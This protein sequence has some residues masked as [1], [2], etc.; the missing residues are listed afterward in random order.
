MVLSGVTSNHNPN[1][2]L[3]CDLCGPISVI[4]TTVCLHPRV[5]LSV[6]AMWVT[7]PLLS[8]AAVASLALEVYFWQSLRQE[9]EIR[10][11]TKLFL[12]TR[13][14]YIAMIFLNF[15]TYFFYIISVKWRYIKALIK[16]S[17]LPTLWWRGA[18]SKMSLSHASHSES[19]C[20]VL[21]LFVCLFLFI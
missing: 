8:D 19:W 3:H 15:A 16:E 17:R 9:P 1:W 5:V 20:N 11:S 2:T 7:S 6:Q 13:N 18:R 10:K 14:L 4:F 12:W 21:L